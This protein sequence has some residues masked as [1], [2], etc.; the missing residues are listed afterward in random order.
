MLC[1]SLL[2]CSSLSSIFLHNDTSNPLDYALTA[3]V[4]RGQKKREIL[5]GS[6]APGD[7]KDVWRY[8]SESFSELKV[9]I[10]QNGQ[11]RTK[12]F[13][14]RDLPGS[15]LRGSS[16][17]N[18]SYIRV[19]DYAITVGSGTGNIWPDFQN[20]LGLMLIPCVGL[21]ICFG[22]IF[23]VALSKRTKQSSDANR[24]K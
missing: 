20:S 7:A 10:T 3:E 16:G 4:K 12:E 18:Q 15:L 8:F 2:S 24:S 14:E 11:T 1:L 6:V 19:T 5:V 9:S 13:G 17:G 22:I 21:A 23:I